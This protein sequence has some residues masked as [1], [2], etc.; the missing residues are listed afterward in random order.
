MLSNAIQT[1]GRDEGCYNGS[2][3]LCFDREPHVDMRYW[4]HLPHECTSR[5]SKA[6]TS[7]VEESLDRQKD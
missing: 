2:L 4:I 6:F 5:R 1:N 3:F 7:R